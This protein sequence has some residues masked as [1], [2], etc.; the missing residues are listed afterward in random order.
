MRF[1][2]ADDHAIVRSGL[3]QILEEEFPKCHIG[4]A[5]TCP[6]VLARVKGDEWDALILDVSMAG[7]NSLN[8]LADIKTARPKMPVIV[9][10]MHGERQFVIRALREGASAYLTK[11][12]APEELFHAI[13][14]V[15]AGKR[16]I[17]ESLAEQ[18]ADH[19]AIGSKQE[20]HEA[21]SP[22]EYEILVLLARAKSVSDI[23]AELCLSAKTVSTYRSR[24]LEKMA[25]HSNAELMQYAITH[26][27]VDLAA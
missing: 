7:Q 18:I 6:E 16:Y 25:L 24:I 2:L 26:G 12:R 10:S 8:I 11:E 20:P 3:R 4:E 23:A 15:L 14:T 21:L 17:G 13:R 5:A 22:R 1:L 27:L 9:L 19:L